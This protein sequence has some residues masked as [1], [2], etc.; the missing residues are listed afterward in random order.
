MFSDDI[1]SP[2][3]MVL[4]RL[5]LEKVGQKTGR[6]SRTG[7][8]SVSGPVAF[9]DLIQSASRRYDLDP[10]LLKAVIQQESGFRPNVVSSAGAMGLMQLMPGTAR[11][12]GVTNPF[13]PAQNIDGGAR[14]LRAQLDRFGSLPLALAAYNAGPGAVRKYAGIP[15]YAETQRF[16]R[17]VS[18]LHEQYQEWTV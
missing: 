4:F 15:P 13:D 7:T 12:L 14:Y 3:W 17:A 1:T 11:S 18:A 2:M 9:E 5:M 16:I 10:A 6:S 8:G